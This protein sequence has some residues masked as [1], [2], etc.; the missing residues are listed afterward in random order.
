MKK[1]SRV[2]AR[3]DLDA[4]EYNIEMMK[5]NIKEGVQI[6]AVIK[7]DGYGHGAAQIAKV[8]DPKEYIWGFAAATLDEA[9]HLKRSGIKKPILVL[10]CIF[11][12][13][14]ED[15]I[16]NEIRMTVFTKEMAEEVSELA[17]RMGR[18]VYVHIKLDTGMGRLGFQITEE[19][20]DIIAAISKLP[21]LVMEGMF[22]HFSKADETDK[23][24]THEQINQYLWMKR[25][26]EE[27]NV[28]FSYYH[29][30][31]SAG[32]IDMKEANLNLVR[33]GISTYGMYPSDEVEKENVPLKPAMELISHVAFVKWVEE[34][35]RISYGGT[36]VTA[37][38]TKVATIPVGYGDGYPR[39]LSNQ[40]Y[41]LIHGQKAP[42]L[43]RV[44]MD[45]FMV[46][47]TGIDDVKFGDKV[48]LIGK[49]G[50]EVLPV[51]TLS[52]LSGRFN[53]EFVCNL[54]KRIPREY[55]RH[56]EIVE[57]VDYFL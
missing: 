57:Q 2:M 5:N 21:N 11:P 32:I 41:V 54:G 52:D 40:G 47:V 24:Y 26:L 38:P 29:C 8:L 34:G 46:D 28:V 23:T 3:V 7:M 50:D 51:E 10:G 1:Y 12:D 4:V 45:Q 39:S 6:M 55:I 14:W 27:R 37:Y 53:Y 17:Q 13:Q 49:D 42:I 48:T 9:V 33:A 22:T 20:A 36:Y 44:C 43:G 56:G 18:K 16:E 31:N 19:N 15:M 25:A 30:S 35:R